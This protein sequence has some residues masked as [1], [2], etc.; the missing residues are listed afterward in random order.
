M[1]KLVGISLS[2]ALELTALAAVPATAG[3][4]E[5]TMTAGGTIVQGDYMISFGGSVKGRAVDGDDVDWVDSGHFVVTF[6]DVNNPDV[7][8]GIFRSDYVT[9]VNWFESDSA[10]CEAAMNVTFEGNFNGI[11]GYQL[12][13]VAG[14]N[15]DTVRISLAGIPGYDTHY[16]G[17]FDDETSCDPEDASTG[18][19]RGNVQIKVTVPRAPAPLDW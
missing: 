2:I 6:H 17:D 13:F 12:V 7:A 4:A 19:D 18:L 16:S 11:P 8:G 15:D 14:D 3:P 10:T 1:R 9:P 5:N